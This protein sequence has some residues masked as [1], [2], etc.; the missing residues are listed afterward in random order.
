VTTNLEKVPESLLQSALLL[1][2]EREWLYE[3]VVPVLME[4]I[5]LIKDALKSKVGNA[6][7]IQDQ[8]KMIPGEILEKIATQ[9]ANKKV[10]SPKGNNKDN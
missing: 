1:P 9:S 4:R 10:T 2:T 5:S 3:N 6:I 7:T 8:N